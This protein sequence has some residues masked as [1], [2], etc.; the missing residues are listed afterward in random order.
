MPSTG[1]QRIQPTDE[2]QQLQLLSRFPEQRAYE[3][4]RPVV[5][6]GL[7]PGE[8]ARQTGTAERTLYR[9]A[10]RFESQ[11]MASLFAPVPTRRHRLPD[12]MRQAI[13]QLKAEY[14]AFRPHE[15]ATICA[16]RFGRRPSPHTVK[17]LLAEEPV[18]VGVH[19]RYPPYHQISEAA[20]RRLAIIRL[21]SEGWNITSIAGYLGIARRT[22]SR[23]LQR[24]IDEGC[25]GWTTR[26]TLAKTAFER[27]ICGPC[28]RC[29]SCRRTRNW[30]RSASTPR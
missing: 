7:S 17:R 20:E 28:W 12:E 25:S 1:R 24:W 13:I 2:W 11:G 16:T 9:Q 18:P 10:G 5:L 15:L 30:A 29:R 23:T 6:F 3:L 4:L 21:H 14:P 19:R 26:R 27:L 8:R 22:V